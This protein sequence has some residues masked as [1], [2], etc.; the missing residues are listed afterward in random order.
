VAEARVVSRSETFRHNAL[1]AEPAG[2]GKH[3]RAFRRVA[4][5]VSSGMRRRS[6]PSYSSRSKA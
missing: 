4:L 2:M 6:L 3:V 1:C 5:R